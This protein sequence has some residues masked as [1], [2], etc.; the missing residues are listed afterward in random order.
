MFI[1]K[2]GV[3]CL[4][5]SGLM[6]C[7]SSI[8]FMFGGF[9]FI[10]HTYKRVFNVPFG[11]FRDVL[12]ACFALQTSSL[13]STFFSTPFSLHALLYSVV[14]L[15]VCFASQTSG[16]YNAFPWP[17]FSLHALLYSVIFFSGVV[18]LLRRKNTTPARSCDDVR[19]LT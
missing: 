1:L 14:F 4:T 3:L 5:K 16:L 6:K 15:Y 17:P 18:G 9:Y 19:C 11:L 2:L 8:P 7:L 13:S 12:Y 10:S